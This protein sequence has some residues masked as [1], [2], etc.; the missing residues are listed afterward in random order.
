VADRRLLAE[1]ERVDAE[2]RKR[3]S[4]GD[5]LS[6]SP[7]KPTGKQ[8]EFLALECFEALYGGAA[9]GGKSDALLMAALQYVHVPGYA[10][11]I[12]RRTYA[13][14]AL[15]GAIM[16]RAKEWLIAKGV[17][18]NDQEKRFR[19]PSGATLTFGYLDTE[20]DR[21]RYQG[22]ELQFIGFDELT[23][24]PEQ[25]YRYLLSRL[26]RVQGAVVPLRARGATNPGGLGHDWVRRRFIDGDGSRAFVPASLSDNTFLDADE[27]RLA[28]SQLDSGTRRQLLDGL[29]V[30][31]S[32][33]L[34]YQYDD[35]R[36]GI[37]AAPPLEHHLLGIDYGVTDATAFT[38]VGW[39][40]HDPTVYVVESYKR[41]GMSPSDAA[42]EAK[43]LVAKYAP[44]QIV[45]DTGGLGKGF[46]E[47]ARR[48]FQLP[49]EAAEKTNK[50]GYQSLLNGDLEASPPR[51][52]VVRS[53]CKELI[54]E[55]HELPWEEDRSAESEGFDNH[56][57]DSALYSWRACIAYPEREREV[58]PL[59]G[60]E[61]F[62]AAEHARM[63]EYLEREV[64]QAKNADH[65]NDVASFFD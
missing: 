14:L 56:C 34:V 17:P 59:P 37:D 43:A 21:Y 9:G 57:A 30:R 38:V 51:I 55:W 60:T 32:G 62:A 15:P 47:E 2:W 18:W 26:R 22:A 64:E 8:K 65:V 19:F 39:R 13:D 24:F 11:L 45:G 6:F 53:T 10:A 3:Q 5:P 63:L 36:N 49:I 58:Q 35:A 27:Y 4:K 48:R 7:H 40:L 41:T 29:W 25:W 50:R 46:A 28:L 31:D 23:Q 20:R 61:A 12:L 54:D 52:R 44:V 33:G 42:V 16:D 1:F